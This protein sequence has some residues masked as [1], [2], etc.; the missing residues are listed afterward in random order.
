VCSF[1]TA[2][3]NEISCWI[4]VCYR[5]WNTHSW[6][7]FLLIYRVLFLCPSIQLSF[8]CSSGYDLLSQIFTINIVFI[9]YFRKITV[10][11]EM[12]GNNVVFCFLYFLLQS[13]HCKLGRQMTLLMAFCNYIGGCIKV[14]LMSELYACQNKFVSHYTIWCE[15]IRSYDTLF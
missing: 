14:G 11:F 6:M 12:F 7:H 8:L 5:V 15:Y 2:V 3:F 13:G 9:F 1:L 4:S 10:G